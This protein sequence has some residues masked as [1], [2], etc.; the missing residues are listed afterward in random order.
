MRTLGWVD[1]D[2]FSILAFLN[3]YSRNEPGEKFF[4]NLALFSCAN[5]YGVTY[6]GVAPI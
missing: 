3:H 4:L 6:E 1:W 2:F 5:P